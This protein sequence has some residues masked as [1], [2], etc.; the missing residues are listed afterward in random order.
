MATHSNRSNN[1]SDNKI[2]IVVVIVVI[3]VVKIII[4]ALAEKLILICILGNESNLDCF[5]P[6]SY[7]PIFLKIYFDTTHV[8]E[9]CPNF[10]LRYQELRNFY[11]RK[12]KSLN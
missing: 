5:I 11:M 3:I 6:N 2:V 1:R 12:D 9:I 7:I 10:D 4:D 8:Q